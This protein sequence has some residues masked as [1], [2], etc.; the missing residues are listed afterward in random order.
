MI[1]LMRGKLIGGKIALTAAIS[2]KAS[3]TTM[4]T[5]P[6]RRVFQDPGLAGLSAAGTAA[7]AAVR[8]R[9]RDVA[10]RGLH[11]LEAFVGEKLGQQ[12]ARYSR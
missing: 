5:T 11:A 8:A 2:H 1:A 10:S 3:S 12:R 6:I 4:K 7:T 9:S